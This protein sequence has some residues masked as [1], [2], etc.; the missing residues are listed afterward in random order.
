MPERIV[1]RREM[2]IYKAPTM[3]EMAGIKQ[4]NWVTPQYIHIPAQKSHQELSSPPYVFIEVFV[5]PVD[6][7][8]R[9]KTRKL[10]RRSPPHTR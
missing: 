9:I 3:S 10:I 5:L 6:W 4:K 2:A 8:D 7:T 1:Q